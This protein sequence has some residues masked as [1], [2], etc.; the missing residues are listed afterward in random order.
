MILFTILLLILLMLTVVTILIV[1][2]I[3]ATGIVIFGDVIVCAVFIALIMKF[4][5]SRKKNRG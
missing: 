4:I 2:T 3:G 1:S 5:V